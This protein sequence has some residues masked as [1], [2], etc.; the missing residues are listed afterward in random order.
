M[1]N[2]PNNLWL[3]LMYV[4]VREILDYW[5]TTTT[6]TTLPTCFGLHVLDG[7]GLFQQLEYKCIVI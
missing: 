6:T 4:Y 3:W 7:I 1:R 5:F 2:I